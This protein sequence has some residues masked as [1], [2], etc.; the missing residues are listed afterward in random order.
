MP[1]CIP[2]AEKS[3]L[4][5]EHNLHADIRLGCAEL[6]ELHFND[7]PR[8]SPYGGCQAERQQHV[9]DLSEELPY[10]RLHDCSP[11]SAY[12]PLGTSLTPAP[13]PWPGG[14]GVS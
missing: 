8:F 3:S 4:G 10:G 12:C 13:F 5:L 1:D 9:R 11:Y 6:P 2:N 7:R 14:L